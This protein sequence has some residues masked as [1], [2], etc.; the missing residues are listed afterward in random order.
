MQP[1]WTR[2]LLTLA[3]LG[4]VGAVAGLNA[5]WLRWLGPTSLVLVIAA[6]VLV[7]PLLAVQLYRRHGRAALAVGLG[8]ASGALALLAFFG[9]PFLRWAL[10]SGFQGV[11]LEA[12]TLALLVFPLGTGAFAGLG[13][14][15]LVDGVR[16]Y[17]AR[18]GLVHAPR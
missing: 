15:I 10:P 8:A 1:A 17:R 18:H 7:A 12:V 4:A 13:T 16:R 3:G 2:A 5:F 9:A 14:L 6:G 11:D